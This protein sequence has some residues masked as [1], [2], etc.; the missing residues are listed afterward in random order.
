MVKVSVSLGLSLR[1][2]AGYLWQ[3]T[4]TIFALCLYNLC[5]FLAFVQYHYLFVLSVYVVKWS[6]MFQF[7]SL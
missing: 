2:G 4:T 1:G 5:S 6:V 3:A 7:S